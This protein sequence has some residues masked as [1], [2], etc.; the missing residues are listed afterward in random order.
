MAKKSSKDF[1]RKI[2]KAKALAKK[3]IAK[4]KVKIAE[5]DRKVTAFAK[6]DPKKAMLIAAAVGAA[7]GAGVAIALS[8]MKKK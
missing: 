8:R 5:A 6:K 2:A 7:V 1:A 4:A 3:E